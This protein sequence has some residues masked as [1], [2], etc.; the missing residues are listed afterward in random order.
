VDD[1]RPFEQV[2]SQNRL[3]HRVGDPLIVNAQNGAK[4]RHQRRVPG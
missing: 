2:R 4:G 1:S 3:A